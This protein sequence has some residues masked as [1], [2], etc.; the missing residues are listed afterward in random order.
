[1]GSLYKNGRVR[2]YIMILL[3]ITALLIAAP[4]KKLITTG[5]NDR[6]NDFTSLLHEKTGLSISYEKLSPSLLSNFYI[7]NIK[8]FDDEGNQLLS[9]NRTRVTYSIINLLKKDLQRG[10]S[11]VV[12]DGIN[13]DIDELIKITEKFSTTTGNQQGLAEIKKL[14]PGNIKLKNI[15]LEYNDD[16][17]SALLNLKNIGVSNSLRK[18]TIDIQADAVLNAKIAAIKRNISGKLALS[19]SVTDVFDGSQLNLKLL[20][21]TDGDFRLN[22]LNLHASYNGGTVEVHTIQAVNP[23]SIGLFMILILVML[24]LSFVWKN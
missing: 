9:V 18:N 2:S 1:M 10:I 12:I 22:K 8:V 15:Y 7:H 3:V 21:F 24:M 5:V 13:L 23:V 20:D 11:S 16:N 6:I 17:V 14:I 4:I 19:G